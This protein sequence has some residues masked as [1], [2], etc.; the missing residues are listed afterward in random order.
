MMA[1]LRDILQIS[2]KVIRCCK[3]GTIGPLFF[4]MHVQGCDSFQ[5]MGQPS[6]ADEMLLQPQLVLEPFEKWAIDFV[7][8]FNLPSHQKVYILV[9]IDYVTKWVEAKV[10]VKAI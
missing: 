4:M 7:R 6:Q 2:G 5:Q 3:W 1:P 10:V 9:C 8:P